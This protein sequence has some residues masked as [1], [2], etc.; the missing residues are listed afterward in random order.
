MASRPKGLSDEQWKALCHERYLANAERNRAQATARR[1]AN[2][3]ANKAAVEAW[4][5]ANPERLREHGRAAYARDPVR[6]RARNIKRYGVTLAEYD[7]LLAAQ[8]GVCAICKKKCSKHP[9]LSIDHDHATGKVRGLLCSACNIG[10][11]SLR[12][13]PMI[14]QAAADYLRKHK[15]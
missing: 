9:N 10:I 4:R 15:A 1:R 5:K 13:D 12:E 7:A 3:E 2:P 14:A 8:D 11:G 6:F